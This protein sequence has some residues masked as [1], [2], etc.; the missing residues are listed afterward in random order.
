MRLGARAEDGV[1]LDL[2]T[3]AIDGDG[4]A[5]NEGRA[6]GHAHAQEQRAAERTIAG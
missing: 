1:V 6:L 4:A 5:R 2:G 3:E